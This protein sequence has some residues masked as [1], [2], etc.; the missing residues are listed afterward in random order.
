[1]GDRGGI[2]GNY[3]STNNALGWNASA[4]SG[5][6]HFKTSTDGGQNT[7]TASP[8]T[9]ALGSNTALSIQPS[10]ITLKFWKRLT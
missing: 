6:Q 3:N 5:R 2:Y 8:N 4:I 9:E 10:Y 7:G 1:M